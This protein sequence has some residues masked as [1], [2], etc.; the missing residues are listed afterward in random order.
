MLGLVVHASPGSAPC[1][2]LL[3]TEFADHCFVKNSVG[4]VNGDVVDC[5]AS[6][7]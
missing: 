1:F 6:W 5:T 7:T 3:G 4:Q 2:L